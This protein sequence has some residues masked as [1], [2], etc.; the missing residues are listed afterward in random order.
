MILAW[1]R[2]DFGVAQVSHL[3]EGKVFRGCPVLRQGACQKSCHRASPWF[4]Q[5]ACQGRA[6][7]LR[8][9]CLGPPVG[10]PGA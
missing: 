6:I 5:G 8:E 3:A 7:G 10:L 2:I 9:A 4:C 1:F